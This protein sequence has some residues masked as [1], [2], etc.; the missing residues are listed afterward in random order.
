MKHYI[1]G[2]ALLSLAANLY[3]ANPVQGWYVG[4][5]GGLSYMP[6]DSFSFFYP[7]FNVNTVTIPTYTAFPESQLRYRMMGAAGGQVGYRYECFRFELQPIWNSNTYSSIHYNGIDFEPTATPGL[8]FKGRTNIMAGFVNALYE[9]HTPSGDDN[10]GAYIGLGV[11]YASIQNRIAFY[12]LNNEIDSSFTS[13]T[14]SSV[15]GQGIV[16]LEYFLDDFTSIGMDLRFWSTGSQSSNTFPAGSVHVANRID[17]FTN[18][19]QVYTANLSINFALD[20]VI[21]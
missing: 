19:F 2:A 10:W 13:T 21:G 16:G 7:N 1:K 15:I 17:S 14:H 5:M 4:I 11:G 6:K 18:R 9:L 8:T 3:A 20:R 12:Y